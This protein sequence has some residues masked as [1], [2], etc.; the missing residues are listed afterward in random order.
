[1]FFLTWQNLL[2]FFDS[3]R[4]VWLGGWFVTARCVFAYRSSSFTD[5]N[6]S[7]PHFRGN[8][9]ASLRPFSP[10]QLPATSRLPIIHFP[11]LLLLPLLLSAYVYPL[12]YNQEIIPLP[13][14]HHPLTLKPPP[15][16][17]FFNNPQPTTFQKSLNQPPLLQTPPAILTPPPSPPSSS[18][19][20]PPQHQKLEPP[21]PQK[22]I[23]SIS[24]TSQ[25]CRKTPL[26]ETT[27]I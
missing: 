16:H 24:L 22:T 20:P 6:P 3:C 14:N 13:L 2:F 4:L 10:S 27:P 7:S 11:L 23:L 9:V 5:S 1:M 18:P 21:K 19:P 17:P 8:T 12:I 25:S 26:R 15:P